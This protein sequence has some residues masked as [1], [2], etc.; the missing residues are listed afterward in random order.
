MYKKIVVLLLSVLMVFALSACSKDNKEPDIP[1]PTQTENK[2]DKDSIPIAKSTYKDWKEYQSYST[3]SEDKTYSVKYSFRVPYQDLKNIDGMRA[4]AFCGD[5]KTLVFIPQNEPIA[6][7]W[8]LSN[9]HE[10]KSDEFG[11]L[12]CGFLD[13]NEQMTLNFESTN[14]VLI[15]N[16]E[17]QRYV[18]KI[19]DGNVTKYNVVAYGRIVDNNMFAIWAM[20]EPST[21]NSP[22]STES[23]E[24]VRTVAYS[25][26]RS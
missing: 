21:D 10:I 12:I 25:C 15:L 14:N 2:I 11:K 22:M 16:T 18:G 3:T 17:M 24:I 6:E 20:V 19:T 26:E 4:K 8:N 23:A 9:L 13:N 1:I 5:D 7:D